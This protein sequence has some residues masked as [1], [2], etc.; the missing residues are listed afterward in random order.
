MSPFTWSKNLNSSL[1]LLKTQDFFEIPN[2]I[3]D[4]DVSVLSALIQGLKKDTKFRAAT[5]GASRR[6]ITEVRS[7]QIFWIDDLT[8]LSSKALQNYFSQLE[9]MRMLLNEKY[10]LGLHALE[11]H[12]SIYEKGTLYQR[13][14]D[15]SV[16]FSLRRLSI[17]CYLNASW[18]PE[19]GGELRIYGGD[20][21][22]DVAPV[23]GKLVGFLSEAVEHE[24]LTSQ[25]ERLSL[26]SWFLGGS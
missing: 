2:F 25:Q 1:D 7:D 14:I 3:N 21:F 4:E 19:H 6:L 5:V 12:F 11:S 16:P 24:V 13:H 10:F 17:I 23:G 20:Q 8:T 9:A 18:R 22:T 15:K 26:T